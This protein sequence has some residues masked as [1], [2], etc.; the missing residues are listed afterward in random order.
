MCG[1]FQPKHSTSMVHTYKVC[2]RFI[3]FIF[4]MSANSLEG[5]LTNTDILSNVNVPVNIEI[6]LAA[7]QHKEDSNIMEL[8]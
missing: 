6:M 1:T 4:C 5:K 7:Q 2:Q 3:L 8:F